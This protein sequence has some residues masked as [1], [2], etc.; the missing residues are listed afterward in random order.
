MPLMRDMFA[1][2]FF[3]R[4][5][6]VDSRDDGGICRSQATENVDLY[7]RRLFTNVLLKLKFFNLA[8]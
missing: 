2:Y 1:K 4:L 3:R 7:E 5:G 6:R 8:Y